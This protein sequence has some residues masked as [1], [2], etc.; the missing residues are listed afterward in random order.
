[1][2]Q[3]RKNRIFRGIA[4]VTIAIQLVFPPLAIAQS[5]P[6]IVTDGR[7][8][9]SLSVNGSIT[10]VR[11]STVRGNTGLNSFRIFNVFQNNTVNLFLPDQT[12]NLVNM[13]TEQQTVIDGFL[14]AY[15]DGQIGG[16][17]YFLNP[18]G[19]MVGSS[20]VINAGA[21]HFSTPTHDFMQSIFPQG[22]MLS[23][24]VLGRVLD[25][26]MP[27]SKTGVIDIRGAVNAQSALSMS[28]QD[29][30]ISGQVKSGSTAKVAVDE[31]VNLSEMTLPDGHQGMVALNGVEASINLSADNNITLTGLLSA[32]GAENTD[33][34]VV[35]LLAGNSIAVLAG[36]DISADGAGQNSDGGEVMVMAE[37]RSTLAS[38]ASISA[39]AGQSGDGGF[40]E[41]SARNVVSLNGGSLSAASPSG[42][43]GTVLI[44]P[45]AIEVNAHILRDSSTDGGSDNSSVTWNAGSLILQADDNITIASNVVVSSRRVAS[46]GDATAHRN[47]SSIAASGD[48]TLDSQKIIMNSGSLVTAEGTSGFAGGVV[49][50]DADSGETAQIIIDNASVK[51]G[52]IRLNADVVQSDVSVYANPTGVARADI[53][54]TD[55]SVLEAGDN[56]S[57][58]ANALQEDP[59]YAGGILFQFDARRAI[60]TVNID[61]SALIAD[62]DIDIS[63][64]SEIQTDL[65]K[66]GWANLASLLP[67][68]VAVA[69]TESRTDIGVSG[70]S[71]ISSA[72]GDVSIEAGAD[73]RSTVYANS[74]SLGLGL[75]A[76]V[77]VTDNQANVTLSDTAA[78]SGGDI[79]LR[80]R[81]K[82]QITAVGDASA[83]PIGGVSGSLAGAVGILNDN[84]TTRITDDTSINASGD[85]AL[86]ADSEVSA[87]FAARATSDDNF[88]QTVTDKF[89]AGIDNTSQL[90]QEF[91]GINLADVLKSGVA[92]IITELA[93]ALAPSDNGSGGN[94]FQIGGA[95]V[96]ADVKNNTIAEIT[97]DN[98][99]ADTTAPSVTAGGAVDVAVQ[100]ITQTQSFASGRTD[101]PYYW[102]AGRYRYSAGGEQADSTY[103]RCRCCKCND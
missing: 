100:G 77:S 74:T 53:Q 37:N 69:V 33:A 12:D 39:D 62:Q 83:A 15:K 43:Q 35:E 56:I 86:L 101:N 99:S 65:S 49:S 102:R 94:E 24:P 68:D 76:G 72:S 5:N 42:E 45:A 98:A 95:L 70:S 47:A 28:A 36:A 11:T 31:L 82:S 48:I 25:N 17:V 93:S 10:D 44:D 75:V 57:V 73:T 90:D 19:V 26:D 8:Q 13:V 81:T 2:Y 38:G 22:N 27:L 20:G 60:S 16:N 18:Y 58:S 54:I 7:T 87:I 91:M 61:D 6:Q 103:W 52:E 21:L 29:I 63:G 4:V 71:Q 40:V 9:T 97:V 64:A 88:T 50:F 1:M 84:T 85:V 66:Q 46:A 80:S 96:Y 32:D 41:F 23:E 51:G 14:N 79:T 55:G 78:V 92:D 3:W 30:S 59:G 67:I 34:G 89:D